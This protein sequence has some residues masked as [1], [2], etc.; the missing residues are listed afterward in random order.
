MLRLMLADSIADAVDCC[1]AGAAN[2]D[3][4]TRQQERLMRDQ[5]A[6]LRCS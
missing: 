2:A 6:A 4:T 1:L 3:D 5:R